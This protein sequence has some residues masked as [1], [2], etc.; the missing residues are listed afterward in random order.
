MSK[1]D[2]ILKISSE[3]LVIG[4]GIFL[5]MVMLD[6]MSN[7]RYFRDSCWALF[8][9]SVIVIAPLFSALYYFVRWASG[10]V[11]RRQGRETVQI[12]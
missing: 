6:R 10:V 5:A 3:T 1:S 7:T 12:S 2:K 11:Q 9:M 8:G 4:F